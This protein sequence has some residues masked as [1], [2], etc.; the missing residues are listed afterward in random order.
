MVVNDLQDGQRR[1]GEREL[2]EHVRHLAEQARARETGLGRGRRAAPRSA[3]RC[4]RPPATS[5]SSRFSSSRLSSSVAA[6]NT[7]DRCPG[8]IRVAIAANVNTRST[9]SFR[10]NEM[11][12]RQNGYLP[13]G[14]WASPR[15]TTRSCCFVGVGPDEEPVPRPA[16]RL[17]QAVLDLDVVDVEQVARLELGRD[18]H[19]E[20]GEQVEAGVQGH[21]AHARPDGDQPRV[22]EFELVRH[23]FP[24][25]PAGRADPDP[26]GSCRNPNAAPSNALHLNTSRLGR[27]SA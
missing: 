27:R 7:R 21:V 20:L 26:M 5:S 6:P 8:R 18:V 17:D 14:G 25:R 22:G 11:S 1:L 13:S 3:R 23:G 24:L 4:D 10:A 19:A 15:K 16:A 9:P 12:C 2:G